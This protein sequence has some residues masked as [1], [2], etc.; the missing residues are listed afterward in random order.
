MSLDRQP[1]W[2]DCVAEPLPPTASYEAIVETAISPFL[3]M[4][5]DGTITWAAESIRELLGHDP[6][7]LA[8]TSALDLIHPDSHGD[9]LEAMAR[10]ET[11]TP[12]HDPTWR[13]SGLV[14]DVLAADGQRVS[15]DVSVAT[16]ART[17]LGDFVVQLRRAIGATALQRTVAAMAADEPIDTVLGIVAAMFAEGL[18]HTTF[19]ILYDWKEG[20]FT[21]QVGAPGCVAS[22]D[23][24]TAEREPPPPWLDGTRREGPQLFDS[25]ADLDPA[26][27]AVV[28]DRGL[29]GAVVAPVSVELIRQP[30]AV[31]IAWWESSFRSP[32]FDYRVNQAVDLVG[33]ILS[34]QE[35]R[36]SLEWEASHDALTTLTNRRA[37]YEGVSDHMASAAPGTVFYVD[38]DDFKEVN[39]RYGHLSGDRILAAFAERLRRSTRPQD[40]VARLGG[41][42]FAVFCPDLDDHHAATETAA[43]FV[44]AMDDPVTV[45]GTSA[46]LGVSIGWAI[47]HEAASPNEVL[48]IADHRL[49]A[50]KAL[51][52]GQV[53]GP[54][55]DLAGRDGPRSVPRP[56]G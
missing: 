6:A 25:F 28:E 3:L 19:E 20:R 18:A 47:T 55:S 38:L 39:D 34:W 40:L 9:T 26:T 52:K 15:C 31:V 49:L 1:H 29:R 44:A 56:A 43:R 4:A 2:C 8:G 48:A 37:F 24:C 21:S 32:I 13:S 46:S 27:R 42:E 41:D 35:G 12:D 16:P 51:G 17:G 22:L 30:A 23:R 14:V 54:D 7:E 53:R 33:L 50:A 5:Q 45:E 36:R 11:I 10:I